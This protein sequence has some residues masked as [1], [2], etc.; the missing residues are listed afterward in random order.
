M[1]PNDDTQPVQIDDESWGELLHDATVQAISTQQWRGFRQWLA[2]VCEDECLNPELPEAARR[3]FVTQ[4]GLAIWRKIPWQAL[5]L[6]PFPRDPSR[7]SSRC[8]CG[9][10][11]AYNKCCGAIGGL[12]VIRPQMAW[13]AAI[14]V[15]GVEAV[16]RA[17]SGAR[18][19]LGACLALAQ[20]FWRLRRPRKLVQMLE[21][22]LEERGLDE[23][24]DDAPGLTWLLALAYRRLGHRR[25][26]EWLVTLAV[27]GPGPETAIACMSSLIEDAS[28]S[29]RTDEARHW[30]QR[31]QALAPDHP[32]LIPAE[33]G[34]LLTEDDYE[35]ISRRAQSW[36][37]HCGTGTLP[38]ELEDVVDALA[39]IPSDQMIE[40]LGEVLGISDNVEDLGEIALAD[41]EADADE[42]RDLFELDLQSFPRLV[43]WAEGLGQRAPV[44]HPLHRTKKGTEATLSAPPKLARLAKKWDDHWPDVDVVAP[45]APLTDTLS[46]WQPSYTGQWLAFL[47]H[48]PDA[49]DSLRILTEVHAAVSAVRRISGVDAKAD[50]L[51]SVQTTLAARAAAIVHASLPQAGDVTLPRDRGLNEHALLMLYADAEARLQRGELSDATAAFQRVLDLEPHDFT[52][53]REGLM[54]ALLRAGRDEEALALGERYAFDGSS[55]MRYGRMLATYRRH[56]GGRTLPLLHEALELGHSEA[57]YLIRALHNEEPDVVDEPRGTFGP[58]ID[59]WRDEPEARAWLA[60]NLG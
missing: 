23:L 60:R 43:S 7:T 35:G 52:H 30:L 26:L 10:R 59:V 27:A 15:L 50:E 29:G 21:P 37:R 19:P 49:A 46:P 38:A 55:D 47:E 41:D 9:A 3:A 58:I 48:H 16:E 13:A 20:H 22:V 33:L 4:V 18:A 56:G 40:R 5:G 24:G 1:T 6:Q 12:E 53:A 31:A 2:K 42:T 11:R 34:L 39:Q 28:R 32:D 17:L 45:S 44:A 51:A 36:R 8:A 54:A 25:K 14:E 57:A